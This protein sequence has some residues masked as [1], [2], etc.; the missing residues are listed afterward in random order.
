MEKFVEIV[1]EICCGVVRKVAEIMEV[2]FEFGNAGFG[3]AEVGAG[4]GLEGVP[5]GGDVGE[6]DG[7]N[8]WEEMG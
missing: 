3:V 2:R 1:G 4:E 8:V 6:R 5:G 7:G